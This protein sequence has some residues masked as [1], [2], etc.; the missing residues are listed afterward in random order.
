M[1]IVPRFISEDLV[2]DI[3]RLVA[4]TF[5]GFHVV[6]ALYKKRKHERYCLQKYRRQWL[7]YCI[8]SIGLIATKNVKIM[9]KL[10]KRP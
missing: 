9:Q 2:I 4:F 10:L 5:S 8:C 3:S 1:E 7:F 6:F